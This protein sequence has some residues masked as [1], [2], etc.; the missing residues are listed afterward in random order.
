MPEKHLDNYVVTSIFY[1][2]VG[3]YLKH[4]MVMHLTILNEEFTYKKEEKYNKLT[5]MLSKILS[6]HTRIT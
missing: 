2:C 1:K 4:T 3:S 6:Y 5:P